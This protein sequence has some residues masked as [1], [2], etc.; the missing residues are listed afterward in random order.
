[1]PRSLEVSFASPATVD[2]VLAAFSARR[3]WL[4][5]L[6]EFG[7]DK[8]LETLDVAADGTVTCVVT[9]DLRRSA[10]PGLLSKV[11]RGDLNVRSTEVWSPVGEG[12]VRGA[13]DVAVMGAPGSGGG[14]AL[15]EPSGDGSQLSLLATVEFKVP[16][17]GGAVE[18]L[19][20]GQFVDGF[21]DI[22]RF[23]DNWIAQ[24]A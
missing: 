5:R 20:A 22:H 8:S 1:M 21:A 2:E 16:L 18:T 12:L 19:V 23:T 11:Y 4:D 14:T 3:Y 10:L 9:E 13:I 17:I 15:L 6:V 7:G 24:R